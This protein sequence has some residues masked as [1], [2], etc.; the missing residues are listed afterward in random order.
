MWQKAS[1]KTTRL[2][3]NFETKSETRKPKEATIQKTKQNKQIQKQTNRQPLK[4]LN[5]M[6]QP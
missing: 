2:K 4:R 5:L 1:K 3:K 6:K